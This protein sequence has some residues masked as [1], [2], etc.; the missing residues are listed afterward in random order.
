MHV[1]WCD[2]LY[3]DYGEF[4]YCGDLGINRLLIVID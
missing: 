4:S 3:V 2:R 1:D